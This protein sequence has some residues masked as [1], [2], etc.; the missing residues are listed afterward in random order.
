MF[1]TCVRRARTFI[2]RCVA[3]VLGIKRLHKSE[4]SVV[5]RDPQDRTVVSVK[6]S[7][8]PSDALPA[9]N[10][11]GGAAGQFPEESDVLLLARGQSGDH[12]RVEGVDHVVQQLLDE[13]GAARTRSG[14][15][16]DRVDA[17][18]NLKGTKSN[19]RVRESRDDSGALFDRVSILENI[20]HH[21]RV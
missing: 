8:S 4:R 7:V 18:R 5:D 17:L 21:P 3:N 15:T 20:A 12:V 13:G 14:A 16:R 6:D 9:G 10:E 2:I 19:E 1:V 11:R